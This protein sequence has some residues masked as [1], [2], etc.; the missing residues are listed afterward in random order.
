MDRLP[1]LGGRPPQEIEALLRAHG[2]VDVG[3]DHLLDLVAA[4]EERM[5][6]EGLEPRRRRRHVVW[7]GLK[8]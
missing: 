3:S 5:V 1:F 2:L 6:E 7:G 4:Q 8:P